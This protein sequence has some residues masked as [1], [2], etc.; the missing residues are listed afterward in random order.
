MDPI[1]GVDGWKAGV[2][3]VPVEVGAVEV[4]V[5]FSLN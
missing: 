4:G 3:I 2:L 1:E 5:E